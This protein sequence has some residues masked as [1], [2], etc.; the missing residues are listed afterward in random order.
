M[1]LPLGVVTAAA[2][3]GLQSILVKP[4]RRIGSFEA[5]VTLREVHID[6]L[7]ITEQ[8]VEEGSQMTDH[9]FRRPSEVVIECAW[10][11][12]PQRANVVSAIL[13]AIPQT[14]AGIQS[15]I[16]GNSLDQVRQTYQRLLALQAS[17]QPFD[18][19]TGKRSYKN[20]L[21]KSLIVETDK[22]RENILLVTATLREVLIASVKTVTI[23]APKESQGLP[24]TTMPPIDKGMK[25][26]QSAPQFNLREAIDALTPTL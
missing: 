1:G 15:I 5:H 4:K 23:P 8:P 16:T 24:S 11:N 17:R 14:I 3:L 9:S 10:S 19:L 7:E 21:I 22:E 20:M 18:V 6:E 26:P 12:S 2:Q 13:G 25:L